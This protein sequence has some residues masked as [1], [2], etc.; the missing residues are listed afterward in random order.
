[1]VSRASLDTSDADLILHMELRF[2]L[3]NFL[4]HQNPWEEMLRDADQ[5]TQEEFTAP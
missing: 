2:I 4:R 1:M 5:I 3:G